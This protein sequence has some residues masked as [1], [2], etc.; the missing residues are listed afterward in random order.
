MIEIANRIKEVRLK[1]GMSQQDLATACGL[2]SRSSINK[3]EKNT[4]EPSLEQIK[5][6]AKALNTDADYLVFG[7]RDTKQ[8]EIERLF[9]RLNEQQQEAVLAFLRTLTEDR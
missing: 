1:R 3:I 9:G 8:E 5:K 4:Y 6:I 2:K 7:N